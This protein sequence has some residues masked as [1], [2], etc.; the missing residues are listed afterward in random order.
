MPIQRFL[1]FRFYTPDTDSAQIT[2][3]RFRC[4]FQ[5]RTYESVARAPL[6]LSWT[7]TSLSGMDNLIVRTIY[8]LSTTSTCLMLTHINCVTQE[9]ECAST[10]M[11]CSHSVAILPPRCENKHVANTTTNLYCCGRHCHCHWYPP[12][13]PSAIIR[14]VLNTASCRLSRTYEADGSTSRTYVSVLEY[15]TPHDGRLTINF[16]SQALRNSPSCQTLKVMT[17]IVFLTR[18]RTTY[19]AIMM[20]AYRN[21]HYW[22][23]STVNV[24]SKTQVRCH[25]CILCS[26]MS[27]LISICFDDAIGTLALPPLELEPEDESNL[28]VSLERVTP[29]TELRERYN[30]MGAYTSARQI[31]WL[32]DNGY[33]GARS[34][35]AIEDSEYSAIR[36]RNFY[37]LFSHDL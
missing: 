14:T 23:R 37:S 36:R 33:V 15:R 32:V 35:S 22:E 10:H 19:L 27:V 7:S 28:G 31:N 29:L 24:C 16:H 9:T 12:P 26:H 5:S 18:Q 20:I 3:N 21:R 2:V 17:T 13:L 30:A 11:S 8:P 25:E 1:V 4:P 6:A 34:I